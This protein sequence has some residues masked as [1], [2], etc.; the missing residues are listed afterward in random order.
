[1]MKWEYKSP[2]ADIIVSDGT[3]LWVYQHDIGQVMVG[4]AS[5][6]GISISNNFLAGIGNLKKDFDIEM[7]GE[8]DAS[9]TLKLNPKMPMPN[10]QR[11]YIVVD[12]KTFLV[13]QTIVHDMLGNETKVIFENI[14]LNQFLSSKMFKFKIPKGVKVIK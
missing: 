13:N 6:S 1:M 11:L 8:N 4:D 10:I 5:V 9:Y 7:S 12:K 3:T 14:K 2:S